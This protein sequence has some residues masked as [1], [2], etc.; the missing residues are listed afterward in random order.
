MLSIGLCDRLGKG[1]LNLD[2]YGVDLDI[3][4]I[5]IMISSLWSQSDRIKWLFVK[6]YEK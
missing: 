2:R 1:F 6:T 3:V 4:I 5:R